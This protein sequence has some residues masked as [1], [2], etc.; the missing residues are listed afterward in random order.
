[1]SGI[2]PVGT[3]AVMAWHSMACVRAVGNIGISRI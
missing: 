2:W 3:A 1:M